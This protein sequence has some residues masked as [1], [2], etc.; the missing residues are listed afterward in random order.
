MKVGR[1]RLHDLGG[2]LQFGSPHLD[3]LTQCGEVGL[4]DLI[5]PQQRVDHHHVTPAEVLDPKRCQ[6]RLVAQGEV[7]DCHPLSRRQRFGK[8]HIGSRR[9]AVR[10]QEIAA[11]IH[12][13]VDLGCGDEL[14]HCD[15]AAAL[16]GQGGDVV[17]GDHH[18]LAVVGFVGLG[19]IAV[20]DNL[21]AFIA[22]TLVFDAAVVL[23]MHLV[24]IHIMVLGGA[25]HLH[26]DVHQTEGDGASPDGS[27]ALSMPI[28]SDQT[29]GTDPG[30][31]PVGI[32]GF[33]PGASSI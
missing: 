13:R 22:D 30:S 28:R 17:F 15:L 6:T 19:D 4:A 25:V 5:W 21:A 8:Q 18:R 24:K 27:H 26:R 12:Q 16:F 23:G 29:S 2:H 32:C 9:G 11:V 20:L 3:V 1:H 7:H 31:S 14:Q 33:A 10:L